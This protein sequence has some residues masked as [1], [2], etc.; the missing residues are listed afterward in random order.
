M[1]SKSRC[2]RGHLGTDGRKVLEVT[3]QPGAS[4]QPTAA[5]P[6]QDDGGFGTR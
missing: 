6:S 2:N 1:T 5:K 4:S 3:V